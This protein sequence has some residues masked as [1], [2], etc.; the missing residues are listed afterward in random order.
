[1]IN[2]SDIPTEPTITIINPDGTELISTNNITAF[3]WIRLEIKKQELEGYK[4]LDKYGNMYNIESNGKICNDDQHPL[5]WPQ[6]MPGSE[7]II[8]LKDLL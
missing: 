7:F 2:I 3:Y 5:L 4:V 8:I 1:M 6:N